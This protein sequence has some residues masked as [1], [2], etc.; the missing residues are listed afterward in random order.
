[1]ANTHTSD[2]PAP[3]YVTSGTSTV[4]DVVIENILN[5]TNKDVEGTRWAID[6]SR[7]QEKLDD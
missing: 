1:M 3:L 2:E 6:N 5:Q 4:N 7:R